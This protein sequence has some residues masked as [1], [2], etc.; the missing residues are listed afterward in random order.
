MTNV[1]AAVYLRISS[2]PTGEHLGVT[3]QREDCLALCAEKGWEP[4][5][6]LDNDVSASN[7]KPRPAYERMLADIEAGTVA[8]VVAWDLDRLHR[9]PIEL[10]RFMDLA[11]AH[12]VA[13]ATA[14][15][16]VDLSTAQG[17][18]VARLK[19][20]VARHETEH[21]VDRQRRAARQKAE[22]GVPQWTRAFGYLTDGSHQ[23]DPATA[24][25]VKEAY[26]AIRA[27]ASLNDVCRLW[28]DAGAFTLNG[29]PWTAA[30]VWAFL[31][32][33]RNAGLRSHN[34][35]IIGP[36]NWPP[37]VD[38]QLWR[39]VQAALDTRRTRPPGRKSLRRHLLTGAL[40]CGKCGHHLRGH[41]TITG[42]RAYVCPVPECRGVSIRAEHIEPIVYRLVSGRLAMPD[43]VGLLKAEIRNEVE[44]EAI[45]AERGTLL[46]R[47][48][49]IADERADGLIDG[50]GYRTMTE[51]IHAKLAELDRREQ[52][53]ERLRVFADLPLGRPEVAAAVEQLTG[54][55]FRAVL[56]VLATITIAPVG[57]GGH[58]FHED[59]VQFTWR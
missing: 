33:A 13:L 56:D 57:K 32:K 28:N 39:D 20:A 42:V 38:E 43:A 10:E 1:R 21:K 11:D 22:R 48:D 6:Y 14:S 18:L 31:R 30:P 19:G 27:G 44:T 25:L 55:R 45:R 16:D 8:A 34:G 4:V 3:R 15:G 29:K 24:P 7:G 40:L 50:R 59:R 47:L 58:V 5:E 37:L 41:Q 17:R 53:E 26:V 52:D 35:E 51:R 46:A 12:R 49:E 36:G 2:D 9:R 23:P 54:D